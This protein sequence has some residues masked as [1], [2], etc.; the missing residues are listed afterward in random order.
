MY[1]VYPPGENCESHKVPT[2]IPHESFNQI[3]HTPFASMQDAIK[4]ARRRRDD[5]N[6]LITT[7]PHLF[8]VGGRDKPKLL[9]TL[10]KGYL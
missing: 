2:S 10:V 5:Q 8:K 3:P 4:L 1:L 9:G 7:S 6:D